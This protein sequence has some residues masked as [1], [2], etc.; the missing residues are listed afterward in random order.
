MADISAGQVRELR[1]KTGAGMMDCKKALVAADGD[2]NEAVD[3]LRKSGAVKAAKK[4]G[5][6]TNEGRISTLVQDNV[7]VVAEILCETDFVA[8]ND[9]FIEFCDSVTAAAAALD[10]EG[11]K[12]AEIKTQMEASMPALINQIGENIQINRVMRWTPTGTVESYIHAGGKIGVL[13]DVEGDSDAEYLKSLCM[14]IAAYSPQFVS[15]DDIPQEAVDK[16]KEIAA[17]QPEL[18]G[19]PPEMLEKILIGKINKW[20]KDVCLT[21]Q[22]WVRDDKIAV[23]K[24]N[25]NATIRR[26]AR[27]S[28]G[29]SPAE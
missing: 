2:I 20:Y 26:F 13:V 15:P 25:P 1:E 8:K 27:W 6:S 10:G 19:K 7:A 28:V 29:E 14:H 21:K 16:E 11:C 17:A 5:R 18:Q 3:F 22:A 12:S 4:A 9:R 23:E 24:A